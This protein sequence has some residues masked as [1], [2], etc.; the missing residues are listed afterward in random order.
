MSGE[1][2]TPVVYECPVWYEPVS[3]ASA[4]R[5][6]SKTSDRKFRRVDEECLTPMCAGANICRSALVRFKGRFRKVKGGSSPRST[7]AVCKGEPCGRAS[8]RKWNGEV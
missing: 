3:C 1:A 2:V 4:E 8:Q 7:E 6:T 5:Q